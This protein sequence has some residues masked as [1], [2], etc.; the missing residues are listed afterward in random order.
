MIFTD[1]LG[2]IHIDIPLS[3]ISCRGFR[4]GSPSSISTSAHLPRRC[5]KLIW[6]RYKSVARDAPPSSEI[7]R[8]VRAGRLL[9]RSSN[10]IIRGAAT[11][12]Y[13]TTRRRCFPRRRRCCRRRYGVWMLHQRANDTSL[14]GH[15]L[16]HVRRASSRPYMRLSG[17]PVSVK[18]AVE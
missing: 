17:F 18:H 8:S 1:R 14:Y 16:G 5:Q 3:R 13:T 12:A 11:T 4:P 9:N 6:R 2:R 10:R 7:T 15:P